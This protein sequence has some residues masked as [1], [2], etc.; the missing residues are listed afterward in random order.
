MSA[1]AYEIPLVPIPYV[2]MTQRGKW[3]QREQAYIQHQ[4]EISRLLS[5][6]ELGEPLTGR[7]SVEIEFRF[8]HGSRGDLD[9]YVKA[10]LDAANGIVWMDDR[11]IDQ[12]SARRVKYYQDETILCVTVIES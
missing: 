7:L 10:L 4:A 5:A 3:G 8:S 2:R 12:L 6:L 11:Q 9:N 1:R